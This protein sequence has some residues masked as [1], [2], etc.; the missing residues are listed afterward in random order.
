MWGLIWIQI[1]A[2]LGHQRSSYLP[3]SGIRV[4][5]LSQ[6]VYH[7]SIL[8]SYRKWLIIN[9]DQQELTTLSKIFKCKRSLNLGHTDLNKVPSNPLSPCMKWLILRDLLWTLVGSR[10]TVWWRCG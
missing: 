1:F 3:T 2:F 5:L 9:E 6:F 4:N 7:L 10:A 8:Q